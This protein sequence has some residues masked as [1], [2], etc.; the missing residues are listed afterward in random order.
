[1]QDIMN[2][3]KNIDSIYNSNTSFNILK[4]FERVLD[5][6]DLYV[7]KNWQDGELC[8]G[9]KVDRHWVTC[10]FM[11]DKQDMPDPMGGKRLL[12]YDCK[13]SYSKDYLIQPRKIKVPDDIRPGTKV[14]GKLDR[15]DIW[16]VEIQ[17][18]KKLIMDIYGGS[19]STN[20]YQEEPAVAPDIA[21][22]PQTA[23]EAVPAAP[24]GETV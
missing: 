23:D 21:S 2:I 19:F 11:W 17:M 7:Y 5:E 10:S 15:K 22:Q 24:E 12:D 3:V 18:P 4:D 20:D 14:K 1:M 16:V 9:P 13:V 6:L 8:A